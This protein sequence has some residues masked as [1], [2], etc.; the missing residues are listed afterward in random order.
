MHLF[1][2]IDDVN[3]PWTGILG[4]SLN[5]IWYWC[6]DQVCHDS[7]RSHFKVVLQWCSP[8]QAMLKVNFIHL[9]LN[10]IVQVIVQRTLASKNMVHAKVL[11]AS[12][13]P[14]VCSLHAFRDKILSG[15]HCLH[16][17]PEATPAL[18]DDFPRNDVEGAL[19]Q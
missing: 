16:E 11:L 4:Q 5:A 15:R 8:K 9:M 6:S 18:A 19:P 3:L 17:L 12:Q 2:T 7:K 1:R 14:M 10:P 13:I